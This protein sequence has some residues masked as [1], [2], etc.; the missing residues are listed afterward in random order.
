MRT[1]RRPHWPLGP[2]LNL[3]SA[4]GPA[5]LESLRQLPGLGDRAAAIVRAPATWLNS[6]FLA[7]APIDDFRAAV[8]EFYCRV[9]PQPLFVESLHRHI[10]RIRDGVGH[11]VFSHDV[12]PV[13]LERCVRERGVHSVCGVGP[14]FWSAIAQALDPLRLPAWTMDVVAGA[15]RLGLIQRK[16][17]WYGDLIGA[18]ERCRRHDPRLTATHVDHFLTLV[19]RTSS[20]DQFD[21]ALL[22]DPIPALVEA[23]RST[24]PLDR[25]LQE[26]RS[27]LAAARTALVIA[28]RS[29]DAELAIGALES[30]DPHLESE[31]RAWDSAALMQWINWIWLDD[32]PLGEVAACERESA[33]ASRRL[34]AA[35]LH[36]RTPERFP[37]WT[38]AAA[39]GLARIADASADS[40]PMYVEGVAALC[41]RYWLHTFE[42]PAILGRLTGISE[43]PV[44]L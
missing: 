22:T 23:E 43:S 5:A 10:D 13:K 2:S 6:Q 24:N 39:A 4:G 42:S 27:V 3:Y 38:S 18:C 41:R 31:A 37:Q 16:R 14:T 12:L 33:G 29:D 26:R 40:Y 32:D 34:T 21:D 8:A 35:V 11:I 44:S 19:G 7:D 15:R 1:T 28:L 25:R 9:V 36:L 17:I 30:I 20:P